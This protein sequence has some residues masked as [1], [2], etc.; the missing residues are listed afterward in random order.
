MAK[1][2]RTVIAWLA[3]SGVLLLVGLNAPV[4][5]NRLLNIVYQAGTIS[6]GSVIIIYLFVAINT[7]IANAMPSFHKHYPA[8][9]LLILILGVAIFA[10]VQLDGYVRS[11]TS[12][13][14]ASSDS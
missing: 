5:D 9:L 2:T 8:W 3:F 6:I 14:Q 10:R 4:F 11:Q 1:K 7:M 12:S 13:Q